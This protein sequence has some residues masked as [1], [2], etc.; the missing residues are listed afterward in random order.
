[1]TPGQEVFCDVLVVGSGAGGLSTAVTA[2][3]AGLEVIVVE[4]EQFFGGTSA[5]SAG[6]MWIPDNVIAKRIGV[7]DSIDDARTYIRHEV[8]KYYD[9][10]RIE[11]YLDNGPKMIEFLE[12]RFSFEFGVWTYLPDYHPETPGASAG[13]RAISAAPIDSRG[14]DPWIGQLRPPIPETTIFNGLPIRFDNLEMKHFVNATRSLQSARYVAKRLL[15]YARDWVFHGGNRLMANGG[16]LVTRLAKALR[17]MDVPLWLSSPAQSLI[18]ENGRVSG[19]IIRRNDREI[20]V[21]ARRAVVLA[22]GGFP[23]DVE[24]RRKLYPHGADEG[25]HFPLAPSGN[26]GDG[27]RLAETV[28]AA[29]D[30]NYE[31]PAAW[32]TASLNPLRDGSVRT[33]PNSSDR[34]KPGAIAV[35]QDGRRFTNESNSYHD[36]MGELVRSSR[37]VAVSGYVICDHH[38]ARRYGLGVAKPAPL[39]L[40]PYVRSGYLVKADSIPSLARQLGVSPDVLNE[41][42]RRFNE[43]ARRGEDTEFKRGTNA[44]NKSQGDPSHRPNASIAP[45]EHAPFYAVKLVPS[46][47]GTFAGLRTDRYARVLGSDDQPIVGLY[48]VGNDMGSVFGGTYLAGGCTLGPAMTFGF[49]AGRHLSETPPG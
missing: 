33:V 41:T 36:V 3:E 39:P 40:G 34:A 19:A 18:F 20:R 7:H 37:G 5:L 13:G 22:T 42:V 25:E 6:G 32:F 49:I 27:L 14:L 8:G 4:K 11:A 21:T 16:A 2:S 9:S 26:T 48:A 46:D 30:L 43:D 35:T 15:R 44:Y 17:E 1:M 38:A 28:G 24:R 29:L 47:L 23:H 10:D 45:L 31:S 12:R